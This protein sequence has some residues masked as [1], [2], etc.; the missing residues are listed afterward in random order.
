MNT[1]AITIAR[2]EVVDALRS[3]LVW[4]L[5]GV[6]VI[7]TV[8]QILSLTALSM[9][10]PQATRSL[11]IYFMPLIPLV[12]L[13]VGYKAVVGERESGSLRILLG[14]PSTRGDAVLGKVLGR[15][16]V[17]VAAAVVAILCSGAVVRFVYGGLDPRAFIGTGIFLLLYGLSWVGIGVGLSSIV[18]TQFRAMAGAVGIYAL[19]NVFWEVLILP[20]AAYAFTGSA[21]TES[22]QPVEIA[23][24]PAWYLY[25]QRL[26]PTQAFKGGSYSFSQ[27]F[28][29]GAPVPPVDMFGITMLVVWIVLPVV[30]GYWRF[31]RE[32]LG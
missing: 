10:V 21:S 4:L 22:L 3:R 32:D 8:P 14:L 11:A 1:R 20:L 26:N 28:E 25:F 7:V 12:G 17:F 16:V 18:S 23:T 9:T 31:N 27:I 2:K 29:T 13:V 15:S 30:I 19:C 6:F 24:E 5:V